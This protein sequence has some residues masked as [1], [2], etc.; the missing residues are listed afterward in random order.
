MPRGRGIDHAGD[1]GDDSRRK[2]AQ[3]G[4]LV[5]RVLVF[6][7]VDTKGLVLGDLGMNPLNL[8]GE[9]RQSPV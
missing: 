4:V 8:W 6:G 7:E 9:L 5:D 2:S 3:F 1:F